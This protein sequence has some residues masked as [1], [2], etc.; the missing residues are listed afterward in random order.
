[1]RRLVVSLTSAYP[2]QPLLAHV[3][4]NLMRLEVL[5]C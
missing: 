2:Y 1:V 5:R 3:Y 4:R